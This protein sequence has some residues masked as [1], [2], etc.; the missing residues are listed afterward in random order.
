MEKKY[1]PRIADKALDEFLEASGAVLIEGPKWCGKTRTARKKAKSVLFMEDP[2]QHN[3]Y[4]K[5]ANT[6][7]SLLLKG[8]T[9]RLI[10]EWQVAPILWDAVRF[11]VD[12]RS[13]SAQF[14]LTGSAVPLDNAVLHTGTGRISRF[15]MRTMSLYESGESSGQISLGEL[16]NGTEEIQGFSSLTI[17]KLAYALARGGWPKSIN[18]KENIAVRRVYDYI[19]AVINFDVNRVDGVEKNPYSMRALMRSLARCSASAATNE[20]LRNDMASEDASLSAPTV[21]SYINA[22]RRI[23]VVED[24]PAWNPA[25]R[26]KTAI[27]T[28]ATR[29]Y[30]DPSIAAAALRLN[31]NGLLQDFNTFGLLFE[32]L[33]IRDLRVYA[34]AIDGEVFHYRDKNGLECDAIVQ[35]KDGRW[36]AVEV[37]MGS[38]EIDEAATNLIKLS[39]LVKKQPI[40][41]M[42]LTGTDIAYRRPDGVFIVPIGCLKN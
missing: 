2:D 10:D 13:D 41:L 42:I 34:Q 12:Q 32:S 21:A 18:E 35:L 1:L 33:C 27:R 15:K 8:K 20:T 26:S 25:V 11:T 40:F 30:I 28:A 17:E 39:S 38:S 9:P 37:K 3:N 5:I 16:F 29:H 36:G 19:E 7:P 31:Q 23:H 14:I 4:M 22:L 6:K 24:L